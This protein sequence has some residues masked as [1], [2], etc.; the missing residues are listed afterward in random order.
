MVQSRAIRYGLAR[1]DERD[2][3]EEEETG[4]RTFWTICFLFDSRTVP[5]DSASSKL[6]LIYRPVRDRKTK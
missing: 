3:S 6:F 5:F 1:A 4:V 2:R